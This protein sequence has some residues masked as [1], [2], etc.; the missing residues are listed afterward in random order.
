[1]NGNRYFLDTNAIVA[2]L[3]GNQAFNAELQKSEW[4]GI[5]VISQIE[6]LAFPALPEPDRQLFETFC[7]RVDIINLSSDDKTLL[8]DILHFRINYKIKLPDAIIAASALQ[9]D[10]MLVTEDTD[11][12]SISELQVISV[13][14]F[15]DGV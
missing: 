11:F 1:M 8:K 5:S 13:K 6:F 12:N 15:S 10:A 2:L 4:V 3:R 7:R 14:S 9:N